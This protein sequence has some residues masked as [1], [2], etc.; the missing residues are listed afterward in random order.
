LFIVAN[1]YWPPD[2]VELADGLP[3]GDGLADELPE[4]D[5]LGLAVGEPDGFMLI[6]GD[7]VGVPAPAGGTHPARAPAAP[8]A[9]HRLRMPRRLTSRR[10]TSLGLTARHGCRRELA[11][12]V[13][14][15]SS[16]R[17]MSSVT[18]PPA[19]AALGQAFRRYAIESPFRGGRRQ[20]AGRPVMRAAR[21]RI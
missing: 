19:F 17:I 15:I 16:L 4:G 7:P 21:I 1:E 9:R 13:M 8:A 20:E 10:L 12:E 18:F 14:S 2:I 5:G 3:E 6:V 11:A